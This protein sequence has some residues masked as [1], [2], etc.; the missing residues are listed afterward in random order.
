MGA[1]LTFRCPDCGLTASRVSG[2]RD[3]GME[4]VVET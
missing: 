1:W 4:T 2:G 3:M